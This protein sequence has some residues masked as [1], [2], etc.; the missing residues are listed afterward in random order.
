MDME[1]EVE[2]GGEGEE[3]V[4][5]TEMEAERDGTEEEV[6]VRGDTVPTLTRTGEEVDNTTDLLHTWK[7]VR[8][9][10]G[11]QDTEPWEGSR[12]TGDRYG[13]VSGCMLLHIYVISFSFDE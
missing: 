10:C 7:A 5:D 11:T 12:P 4:E 13:F 1:V 2:V 3:E 8:S 9:D 6:E